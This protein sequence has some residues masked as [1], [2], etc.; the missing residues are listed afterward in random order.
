MASSEIDPDEEARLLARQA[1]LEALLA[2]VN[3][4]LR[5]AG[6]RL[7]ASPPPSAL[8]SGLNIG[9]KLS[10]RGIER[11][12]ELFDFLD[13]DKDGFLTFSDLRGVRA[14]FL[15]NSIQWED[16]D[17]LVGLLLCNAALH[18][19]VYEC[20]PTDL[21]MTSREAWQAS[22]HE[23]GVELRDDGKLDRD[24]FV[25]WKMYC[26][27]H[28]GQPLEHELRA[29]GL[30]LLPRKLHQWRTLH[31]AWAE[32]EGFVKG[33]LKGF[34]LEDQ[35]ISLDEISFVLRSFGLVIPKAQLYGEMLLLYRKRNAMDEIK[36][37]AYRRQMFANPERFK[38]EI[39]EE[40]NALKDGK[41]YAKQS[42]NE[43]LPKFLSVPRATLFGWCFADR[44]P[45]ESTVQ[46]LNRMSLRAKIATKRAIRKLRRTV[47]LAEAT[48]ENLRR[49]ATF[50]GLEPVEAEA[51]MFTSSLTV[52]D[53][54][55]GNESM[56]ARLKL[57]HIGNG[58]CRDDA[59]DVVVQA[60]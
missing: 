49:R 1:E 12:G 4:S 60:M 56:A 44:P 50:V 20:V 28:C 14:S 40:Y 46:L 42:V 31:E 25:K 52:G 51:A 43:G 35:S 8:K 48:E 32:Y 38:E 21:T 2:R 16:G 23:C 10:F 41:T 17:Q 11:A 55:D 15:H 18:S 22:L 13:E 6:Y 27:E 30:P 34:L 3:R 9:G 54:P 29:L 59:E 24:Q 37:R 45:I 19:V 47:V 39:V 58:A 26:E 5:D 7:D 53:M 36:L 57:H 33:D